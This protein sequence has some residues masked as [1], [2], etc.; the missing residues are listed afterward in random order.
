MFSVALRCLAALPTLPTLPTLR[1]QHK[2]TFGVAWC[3]VVQ[4]SAHEAWYCLQWCRLLV[5][6][7]EVK[8]GPPRP[9][10]QTLSS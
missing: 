10:L 3:L 2:P 1:P 7:T 8:H 6:S 5:W 9:A 4:R